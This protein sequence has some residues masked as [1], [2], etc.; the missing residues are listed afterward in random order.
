ME[1]ESALL[2]SPGET[3][4]VVGAGGKKTTLYALAARLDRAVLTSTVRIPPFADRVADLR[5]TDDPVAALDGADW[6][7]GLVA[8][9]E[10]GR[11]RGYDPAAVDD[12][13]AAH[14]GPVL[15][16]ADGARTRRLKAPNDQ[17]PQLPRTVDTVVPIAS[18]RVVGE[19]LDEAHVHRPD[20]VAAVTGLEPGA[21]IGAQDVATVLASDDGG[22]K[23]VPAG[24]RTLPMVNMADDDR[25]VG[26]ARE[27]AD[28]VHARAG[29]RID[30]V[31]IA[32]MNV[33]EVV[34]VVR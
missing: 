14:N 25:L 18:A 4:A 23:D 34:E 5:V 31:A 7:L 28:G 22:L 10:G 15:V 26:V 24:A 1:P 2:D 13:A 30:G 12:L 33:P 20:R 11:L 8:A 9:D 6:P 17:E 32:R 3:L 21:A 16:K 27:I 19:S 29:D